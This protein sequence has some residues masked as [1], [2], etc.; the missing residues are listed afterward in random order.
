MSKY[1]IVKRIHADGSTTFMVYKKVLWFWIK[2]RPG[3]QNFYT[4]EHA[5]NYI[6]LMKSFEVV[7][8]EVIK[9]DNR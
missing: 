1:R 6:K 7:S 3:L 9:E 5:E 4:L 8:K 2:P